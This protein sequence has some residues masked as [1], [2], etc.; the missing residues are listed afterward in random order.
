MLK[1]PGD[2]PEFMCALLAAEEC[3][4]NRVLANTLN[5]VLGRVPDRCV[6]EIPWGDRSPCWVGD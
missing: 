4:K 6:P 2:I 3:E 5:A 1:R